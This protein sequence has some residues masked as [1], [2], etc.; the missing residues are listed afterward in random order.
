MADRQAN[1]I[2]RP[3]DPG[4]R[5]GNAAVICLVKIGNQPA[6][7]QRH[8]TGY[9]ANIALSAHVRCPF[10]SRRMHNSGGQ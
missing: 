9:H 8:R 4:L 1:V 10:V 7:A 3:F 2:F 6:E 5:Y